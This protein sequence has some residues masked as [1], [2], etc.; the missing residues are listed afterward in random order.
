[1]TGQALA[2]GTGGTCKPQGPE[3]LLR[4]PGLCLHGKA[5]R[6]KA[7]RLLSVRAALRSSRCQD[8]RPSTKGRCTSKTGRKLVAVMSFWDLCVPR[9]PGGGEE[10]WPGDIVRGKGTASGWEG[11]QAGFG[12]GGWGGT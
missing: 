3:P 5:Q 7:V 10:G 4:Q 8:L 1:M 6:R 12:T 9:P 11:L 2:A